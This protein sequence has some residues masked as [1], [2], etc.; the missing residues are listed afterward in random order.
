MSKDEW[1]WHENVARVLL[2]LKDRSGVPLLITNLKSKHRS[3]R[4]FAAKAFA[5]HGDKSDV[6]LLGHCLTDEELIIQL[7]ACEGLERITGVVNRALGQTM[8]TSA[9]IPLWKAWF[10]Q[11]KAKYRTDK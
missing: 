5:E 8:L 6:L 2:Q 3:E 1:C 9:D 7:Q 11:N 4:H 10:D